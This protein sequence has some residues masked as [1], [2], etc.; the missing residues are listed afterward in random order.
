MFC[1]GLV[2]Q[3]LLILSTPTIPE[4]LLS[5]PFTTKRGYRGLISSHTFEVVIT[6][7][8]HEYMR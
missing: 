5:L 8:S 2:V 1:L 7:C 6:E 4:S 3:L